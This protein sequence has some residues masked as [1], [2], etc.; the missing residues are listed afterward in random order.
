MVSADFGLG[1]LIEGLLLAY[2]GIRSPTSVC[3]R[4]LLICAMITALI[5]LIIL[6]KLVNDPL[7]WDGFFVGLK[8][9][10]FGGAPTWISLR[11]LKRD[12]AIVYEA[13]ALKPEVGELYAAYFGTAFHLEIYIG[14]RE[15][16]HYLND[17]FVYRAS[18]EEFLAGRAPKHSTYPDLE[19]VP[20]EA[21]AETVLSEVCKTYP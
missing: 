15:V 17:N 8:L 13:A 21:V 11:A 1:F 7:R 14:G 12:E 18:W 5:G 4:L 19:Y 3:R 10:M 6:L 16:V 9:L 2:M 20:A